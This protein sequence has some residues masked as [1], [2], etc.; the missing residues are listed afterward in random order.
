MQVGIELSDDIRLKIQ[1]VLAKTARHQVLTDDVKAELDEYAFSHP[2]ALLQCV[3]SSR[4]LDRHDKMNVIQTCWPRDTFLQGWPPFNAKALE[5][6]VRFLIEKTRFDFQQKSDSYS[7][8][9]IRTHF[10]LM[11]KILKQ[12]STLSELVIKQLEREIT[13]AMVNVRLSKKPSVGSDFYFVCHHLL[14]M[15][16]DLDAMIL[17]TRYLIDRDIA[18]AFPDDKSKVQLIIALLLL[19]KNTA[20]N[21]KEK[22]AKYKEYIQDVVLPFVTQSGCAKDVAY[23][24]PK[25]FDCPRINIRNEGDRNKKSDILQRLSDLST[26]EARVTANEN[27]ATKKKIVTPSFLSFEEFRQKLPLATVVRDSQLAMNA[28]EEKEKSGL[29]G[30]FFWTKTR[31]VD[32]KRYQDLSVL[33]R[34]VIETADLLACV[35][36]I[37]VFLKNKET[38]LDSNSRAVHLMKALAPLIGFDFEK[39]SVIYKNSPYNLTELFCVTLEVYFTPQSQVVERALTQGN[40][41]ITPL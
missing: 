21:T 20:I 33:A 23:I 30:R 41:A 34:D 19:P 11:I 39:Q 7:D 1:T 27:L 26:Y 22:E 10:D 25:G 31:D 3:L 13:F 37:I 24:T 6:L 16:H 40:D 15:R 9:T 38:L 2:D 17:L 4:S 29:L 14:P 28:R 35:E 12:P 8:E 5:D 36:A 32:T 18:K